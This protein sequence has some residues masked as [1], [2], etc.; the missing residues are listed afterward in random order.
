MKKFKISLRLTVGVMFVIATILTALVAISLQYHFSKK[1]ATEHALS[2]LAMSSSELSDYIHT[3]NVD[4]NHTIRLLAAVNRAID[5]PLTEVE[6]RSI[7]TEAIKD[8]PLFYS[9]YVA[10]EDENFYQVINLDSSP[11]VR[12]RIRAKAID[13]WV[14]IKIT[15]DKDNRIRETAYYSET[16]NLRTKKTTESNY[17]PTERPWYTSASFDSVTKTAPYLFK[18]LKITGQTYSYAFISN[19][20]VSSKRHVLGMDIALSSVASKIGATALGLEENP[21]IESY[22]HLETG[23]IIASNQ[24][25]QPSQRIP[26]SQPLLLSPEQKQIIANT[27]SIKISNQNAWAPMD[28]AISGQPQG[29]AV[30]VIQL[31]E[32][33]TGLHFEFINGFT[34]QQLVNQYHL[35]SLDSLHSLQKWD[36]SGIEGHY[37]NPLYTLP[38]AL[39]TKDNRLDIR[40]L[41]ELDNQT[42]AIL[43]GWSITPQL[44]KDYPS[45]TI[46]EV[47]DLKTGFEAVQNGTVDALIDTRAVLA[48]G[49]NQ[50]YYQN[51]KL[52]DG[53]SD[54]DSRYPNQFY[55]VL[56]PEHA[57]LVPII[58][59]ALNNISLQQQHVLSQK[60]LAEKIEKSDT[61]LPYQA[62]VDLSL[63][64]AE[65]GKIVTRTIN[66][67][68]RFIY[69]TPISRD[70]GSNELLSVII[71]EQVIY[72]DV[73]EKVATAIIIT[74]V[75][76]S[77]TL[78]IAWFFG[79]PIVRPIQQLRRETKKIKA[80][81]YHDVA[82]I[83]T[84][85]KEVWE[86]SRDV[87][88]M[89][90]ALEKHE[91]A[92]EA[93][94]E[95]FIK[96]I[97]QAIDDKSPYTA[98][99]CNRVPELGL[100]LA[101]AA[102]KSDTP[103]FNHFQFKNDDERREFRI[104]A[105]LHDCG[106]ITTPE[107]I[108][109]KGTKLEANYNRIHEIR[110]R[111]EVLWRDA[112]IAALRHI[113]ASP[114]E[115]EMAKQALK[116][117]Q[118]QLKED[119]A[120]IAQAN[121]G[122]EFISPEKVDNIER[123]AAQTWIR[124]FDDRLGLSPI[125]EIAITDT[126]QQV[127]VT[128]TLL[129]DKPQHIIHRDRDVEFDPKFGIKID[130]PEHLYN[131][132]E[133]YNL[134]ISRG[135]LTKEDRYKIN[136]HMIST[137]KMLENLPFPEEL[138]RVPRYASTH[139][140]T[141]KGTGYPRKLTGDDLSIP[142]RIL[143]IADIFE[144][145]TAADRPYKK[146]KPVSVAVDIMY[147]MALDQHLDIALFRLFLQSGIHQQY[148]KLYLK[149][150]QCDE[151]DVEKYLN[152]EDAA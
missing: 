122:S 90:Q 137:I 15:G 14:V 108:V 25:A 83:D 101:E 23:E 48:Y 132:G 32:A 76:M 30:E 134:S 115:S 105:W 138:S 131:L 119:F 147:K 52:H 127:P 92:Q 6:I 102:E 67:K 34:W 109:D 78:P 17:F 64:K 99:H 33:M 70:S 136:E 24:A 133:I 4:A 98:G 97:A 60:W 26:L 84:P 35:K 29:Y 141:L 130:V 85:I 7:L 19:K 63:N 79:A 95:S 8:N 71:P 58:N 144:A 54:L 61:V 9:I 65:H 140:E 93:F 18:H 39:I 117:K 44:I 94:V 38:F 12:D 56:Q 47:A 22:L 100:M 106:K 77:L 128:E 43:A 149:P 2:T 103:P 10:S 96:L 146:A 72:H 53:L 49:L 112:E 51:L 42:I 73:S 89:A 20:Q 69:M 86:L 129:S 46:K 142:E 62:L 59:A 121:V 66:G 135:T 45:I 113:M 118:Q 13:R 91:E 1:M 120:F 104:A 37:T 123:I 55:L 57:A 3:L 88:D 87:K 36:N 74:V 50:Y 5:A 148:A 145:L 150:E 125:E 107:H 41:A 68:K 28:F 114:E 116:S 152:I 40:Q 16:F 31:I 80:R 27:P 126:P 81:Q 151:V 75:L 143:V 139:H 110:T 124:H 21:E 111:F 82:L 11:V